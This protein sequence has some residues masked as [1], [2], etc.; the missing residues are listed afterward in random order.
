MKKPEFKIFKFNNK[1]YVLIDEYVFENKKIYFFLADEELFCTKENEKYNTILDKEKINQIK[2]II[3]NLI[4]KTLNIKTYEDFDWV[5]IS[6]DEKEKI[7]RE[8]TEALEKLKDKGISPKDFYNRVHDV[9]IKTGDNKSFEY[10]K[11]LGS[12]VPK[13]NTVFF[14]RKIFKAR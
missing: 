11:V 4:I 8:S 14:S 10:F 5:E 12:F 7:I 9:K 1:E 2:E 13:L 3:R 6:D